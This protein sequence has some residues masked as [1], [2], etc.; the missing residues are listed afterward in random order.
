[1]NLLF[2]NPPFP[3]ISSSRS[4]SPS[5]YIDCNKAQARKEPSCILSPPREFAGG[6]VKIINAWAP[7]MRLKKATSKP[8]KLPHAHKN[9]F[10]LSKAVEVRTSR[11]EKSAAPLLAEQMN[12]GSMPNIFRLYIQR[13]HTS[14]LAV[15]GP[16]YQ[17]P[18]HLPRRHPPRTLIRQVHSDKSAAPGLLAMPQP[19]IHTFTHTRRPAHTPAVRPPT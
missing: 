7:F 15:S 3:I 2:V 13:H 9:H 11:L 8:F 18:C 16:G 1:M 12:T 4:Q 19:P 10:D 17:L 6:H 14:G 5:N